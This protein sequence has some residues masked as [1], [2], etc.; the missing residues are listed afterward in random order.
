MPRPRTVNRKIPDLPHGMRR[1]WAVWYW[2]GTDGLTKEVEAG[3]KGLGMSMRCGATPVQARLWWEKHVSPALA[4]AMPD[5]DIA[6]TVE[7]LVRKY[8]ADEL[9]A[10]AREQTKQE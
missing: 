1:V 4:A 7:E 9:P 2:R 6:G 8:R 10:L 3:L 5:G